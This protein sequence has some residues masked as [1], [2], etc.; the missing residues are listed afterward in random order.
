MPLGP[1]K[2][3]R[4]EFGTI[5]EDEFGNAYLDPPDPIDRS[6][7]GDDL[8]FVAGDGDT[9]FSVAYRAYL[10]TLDI[11]LDIRPSGFY[12]AIA[13]MNDIT[14]VSDGKLEPGQVIRVPSVVRLERDILSQLGK[15]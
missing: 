6:V 8:E 7:K 1:V 15:R 9:L 12:W 4:L 14:E 3:S 10:S 13:Q 11:E 2:L 5:H